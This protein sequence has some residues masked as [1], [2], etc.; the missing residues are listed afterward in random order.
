MSSV[1]SAA[2]CLPGPR[3]FQGKTHS[4]GRAA[5]LQPRRKRVVLSVNAGLPLLGAFPSEP[6]TNANPGQSGARCL[7]TGYD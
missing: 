4:L 2:T 7:E 3:L 5:L 6:E 1:G